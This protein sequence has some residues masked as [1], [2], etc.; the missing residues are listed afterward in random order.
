MITNRAPDNNGLID[1][2]FAACLSDLRQVNAT[3]ANDRCVHG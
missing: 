1:A 3:S 2:S